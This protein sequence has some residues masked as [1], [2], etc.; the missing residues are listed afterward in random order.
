MPYRISGPQQPKPYWFLARAQVIFKKLIIYII[1]HVTCVS[2]TQ[3]FAAAQFSV[4]RKKEYFVARRDF[5]QDK[6]KPFSSRKLQSYMPTN[7]H[8]VDQSYI[9]GQR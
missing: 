5:L 6:L 9:H 4:A 3:Q 2:Q 8:N 1:M 7:W